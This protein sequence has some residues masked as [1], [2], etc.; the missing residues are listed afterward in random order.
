MRTHETARPAARSSGAGA[1]ALACGSIRANLY[2][3]NNVA[4][5]AHYLSSNLAAFELTGL[6][7]DRRVLRGLGAVQS[8]WPEHSVWVRAAFDR[9]D[10]LVRQDGTVWFWS[11]EE[12]E[13]LAEG[14]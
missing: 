13:R 3:V 12:A 9:G 6:L 8:A 1:F 4:V 11:G 7:A 5:K 10:F 2:I 14:G